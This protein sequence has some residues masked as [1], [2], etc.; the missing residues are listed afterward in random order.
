MKSLFSKKFMIPFEGA[1]THLFTPKIPKK[2][3]LKFK[4]KQST[5]NSR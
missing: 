4:K 5:N 3:F 1:Y 2:F